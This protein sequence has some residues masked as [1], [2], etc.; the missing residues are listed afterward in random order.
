M[1]DTKKILDFIDYWQKAEGREEAE[2]QKFWT[3]FCTNVLVIEDVSKKLQFEY[4][5]QGRKIDVLYEDMGILIE[6]KSRGI[7]LDTSTNDKGETPYQQAKSY[8][9][10]L[11]SNIH[12]NWILTTNFDEIRIYDLHKEYPE[13][14]SLTV[15]LEDLVKDYYL[16]NFFKDPE[17]SKLQREKELS[18][19]A[20]RIIGK[21]YSAFSEAYGKDKTEQDERDL[22][23]LIVRLV[24][25]LY[26]EDAELLNEKSA[27]GNYL[28]KSPTESLRRD[29][30]YLFEES[31]S[32]PEKD[33]DRDLDPRLKAF[34]YI[35]GGLFEES[36]IRIPQFT[37]EL[38]LLLISQA[39]LVFD[40]SQISPTIFG[41]L[42]E[43]TL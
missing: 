5:V 37:E 13:N 24:F 14:E 36:N 28:K 40:W 2:S 20:G 30:K 6:S 15:R 35:N 38:K 4:P 12:I 31:L 41:A 8:C 33:R 26:A 21:L 43:S 23:I 11:P 3:D 34:P 18:V 27:F 42:F 29:L 25:L 16:F 39:S 32:V 9:N 19:E 22:N 10:N 17:F 1:Q 7:N